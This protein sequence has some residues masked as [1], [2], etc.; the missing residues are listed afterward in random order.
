M[1]RLFLGFLEGGFRST[2]TTLRHR[3]P[4]TSML[5]WFQ[6]YR[7]MQR[8][9]LEMFWFSSPVRKRSK[10]VRRCCRTASS[11]SVLSSKSSSSC[12]FTPTC[13][14]TCRPKSSN[15]LRRTRARSCWPPT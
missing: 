3:K 8:S 13:R 11:G 1:M 6:S 5:V 2:F 14:R 7:S 4:I 12:P 10:P 9:R 15:R